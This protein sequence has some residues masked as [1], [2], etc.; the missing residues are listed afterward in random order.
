M[1]LLVLSSTDVDHILADFHPIELQNLMARVFYL[2][3]APRE[4]PPMIDTPHRTT[5]HMQDHTALFMP[6]RVAHPYLQGTSLKVVSVPQKSSDTRGL[7]A[8]TVVIDEETGAVKALVNARALT[9]FRNA[10][11]KL[12]YHLH[13][14]N[15]PESSQGLC[16][17]PTSSAYALH[18]LS[19][20]VQANKLMLTSSFISVSS[21]LSHLALL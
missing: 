4:S 15:S 6:A 16:Y 7:P 17:L 21:L 9:A 12:N 5:I 8:S 13:C 18:Q 2:V 3:S 10:A 11:G 19:P 1:S 14:P 20:S